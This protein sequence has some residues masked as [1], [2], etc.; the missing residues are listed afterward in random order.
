M[1]S[2]E[3]MIWILK[4]MGETPYYLRIQELV[5]ESGISKSGIHKILQNLKKGGFVVQD[6]ETKKYSLGPEIYRLGNVY[7][8]KKEIY[9]IAYPIMKNLSELTNQTISIGTFEGGEA[10]LAY[11]IESSVKN[12]LVGRLGTVY[13]INA[14]GIG[15]ILHAYNSL[16]NLL[17]GEKK[18]FLPKLTEYTIDNHN[19]LLNE[20][21]NIRKDGVVISNEE[22]HKGS[23]G[24][25][26]PIFDHRGKALYCICLAGSVENFRDKDI[27]EYKI[28]VKKAAKDISYILG[29]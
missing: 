28:M 10:I 6:R 17:Q 13:P 22:H 25:A 29:A 21:L 1:T 8:E 12:R 15:K 11:K 9:H 24:V 20:F 18:L 26:S 19:D 14:G 2:Y 3:K 5:E 16:D 23:I 7:I 4:R 27:D